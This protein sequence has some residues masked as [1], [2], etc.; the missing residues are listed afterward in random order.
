M[1]MDVMNMSKTGGV[2]NRFTSSKN[3]RNFNNNSVGDNSMISKTGGSFINND[4]SAIGRK[5]QKSKSP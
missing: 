2:L 5:M 4:S 3:K 1:S